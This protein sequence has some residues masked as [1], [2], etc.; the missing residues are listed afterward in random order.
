MYSWDG[1]LMNSA[2]GGM[3]F[4]GIGIQ[5][6]YNE[7]PGP[8]YDVP[9]K[10][11]FACGGAMAMDAGAFREVG[12]F[13]GEFFAYYEDVDLGWRSWVLG[14]EVRYVPTAVCW[15]HHSSTS[16]RLPAEM[17]RL[18]QTRNPVLACFKNY[19][20]D[21]LR[22]VLAPI[23]ALHARRTWMV[24]GLPARDEEF[25]IEQATNPASGFFRRMLEKAHQ[26]LD[27]DVAVRR[28]AAADLVG[29]NDLLGR[30]EHWMARRQEIQRRRRRSDAEIFQLFLKP[31]WCIEGEGGYRELQQGIGAFYGLPGILPADTLPDPKG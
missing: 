7:T 27:E 14:H 8:E 20:D 9:V 11:L 3:N 25:R 17:I 15:H 6:G 4:H 10:T 12:G 1:K 18:L 26:K 31:H 21:N 30:W 29:R 13:D 2:G 5:R 22:R 19:D 16:R 28:I 24:S 23:L